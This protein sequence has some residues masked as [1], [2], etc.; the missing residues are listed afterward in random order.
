MIDNGEG[1]RRYITVHSVVLDGTDYDIDDPNQPLLTLLDSGSSGTAYTATVRGRQ[2]S[3]YGDPS[4]R[5]TRPVEATSRNTRYNVSGTN[6]DWQL[7]LLMR[8]KQAYPD[9]GI[10][11]TVRVFLE[12]LY[13]GI[14]GAGEI[15]VTFDDTIDS[16]TPSWVDVPGVGAQSGCEVV[17]DGS[18]LDGLTVTQGY[19]VARRAFLTSGNEPQSIAKGRDEETDVVLG[20]ATVVGVWARKIDSGDSDFNVSTTLRWEES[21]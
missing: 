11:N 9:T 19:T 3:I 8:K 20:D 6:T 5:S 2:A 1:E 7:L 4:Q 13:M 15:M 12:S 10:N 17:Q 14:D 21:H 16:G 18:N